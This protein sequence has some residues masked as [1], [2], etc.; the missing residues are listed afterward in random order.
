VTTTADQ[1]DEYNVARVRFMLRVFDIQK[2]DTLLSLPFSG[3]VSGIYSDKTRWET[4]AAMPF[5]L[6]DERFSATILGM[7]LQQALENAGSM[8][9][10]RLREQQ[11]R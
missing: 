11:K 9:T 5:D 2:G 7:A 3:E 6:K 8:V 1:Y 10:Q 4:I